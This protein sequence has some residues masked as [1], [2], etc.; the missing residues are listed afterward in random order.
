MYV[1]GEPPLILMLCD[2]LF[3]RVVCDVA[4]ITVA[5]CPLGTMCTLDCPW[6][7]PFLFSLSGW[8]AADGLL[9]AGGSW[10]LLTYTETVGNRGI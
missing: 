6:V 1:A 10:F 2:E 7:S 8:F 4:V 5:L 9:P 3:N